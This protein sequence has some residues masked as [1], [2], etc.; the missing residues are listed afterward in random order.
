MHVVS[1]TGGGLEMQRKNLKLL[2][3][4]AP[5]ALAVA[6][7]A[8]AAD[9]SVKAPQYK[10]PITMPYSWTGWYVG[11]NAGYGVGTHEGNLAISAPG[12]GLNV[13]QP[14]NAM[15]GGGF[16]G[17]QF[18][19]NYQFSGSIVLGVETDIQ[20]AGITDTRTCLFGCVA[21]NSAVINDKLNW[22]GTTRA[23]AGWATGPVLTYVTGGAA[24]GETQTGL[25]TSIFGIGNSALTTNE[26]KGGWTWGAGVEA[27]LGGNW[28]AKAEYLHVDLGGSSATNVFPT[29]APPGTST[30]T[31]KHEY[32]MFRGGVNYRFGPD[33]S[34]A[35]YPVYRWAGLF[36]GGTI[37]YGL[38]R[39]DSAFT[40]TGAVGLNAE[41]FFLSPRGFDG[42]GIVGYNWQFG[43]WVAGVETDYQGSTGSGYLTCAAACGPALS[44]AIDQKLSSFGTLR[45]RLGYAVGPALFYAT[46]GLAYGD[47]KES[48]TQ[49]APGV[50]TAAASFTHSK[51]GFAAGG[52]IENKLDFFGMLGPNWT[53]RT[54]YL[55][56]DLGSVQDPFVNPAFAASSQSLTSNVHEHIWRTVVSYK[57]GG[58]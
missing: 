10:A 47:V 34:A 58:L 14:F 32:D 48:I 49:F 3:A 36:V 19:Y 23:R 37:G 50:A 16:G 13:G 25:S 33:Q 4:A 1:P 12:I 22:F 5:L 9:I 26:T 57:F 29:L 38:G 17:G 54:E 11:A 42:G 41:T 8:L 27:A 39:N 15:P 21:G 30:Y 31:T 56:V 40:T 43:T 7:P 20:G 46:A 52:G 2:L 18:G 53:T 35:L 44:T 51:T 55:Y 45:G 28:T 6:A 24:Y